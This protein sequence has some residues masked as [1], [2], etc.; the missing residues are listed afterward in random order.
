MNF[1]TIFL[2]KFP[3]SKQHFLLIYHFFQLKPPKFCKITYLHKIVILLCFLGSIQKTR[4][5]CLEIFQQN[6]GE[7]TNQIFHCASWLQKNYR[8]ATRQL[9]LFARLTKLQGAKW[10]H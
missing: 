9:V 8:N 1:E 2:L 3:Y 4:L 6:F 7:D 5:N 10:S